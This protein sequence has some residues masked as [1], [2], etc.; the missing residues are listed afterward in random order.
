MKS[1]LGYNSCWVTKKDTSS[2]LM[3]SRKII[4]TLIRGP[5]SHH[6]SYIPKWNSVQNNSFK[7]QIVE[8]YFNFDEIL[9]H[10]LSNK[11]WKCIFR[12]LSHNLIINASNNAVNRP[13]SKQWTTQ[14]TQT[15]ECCRL[16]EKRLLNSLWHNFTQLQPPN[17]Y[18]TRYE[19]KSRFGA[20]MGSM[21][22][23]TVSETVRRLT[24]ST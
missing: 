9:L 17:N 22:L 5:I 8:R 4:M 3:N 20:P 13:I 12:P 23:V 6:F 19:L 16:H 18:T 15:R 24:V 10:E 1:A 2:I 11:Y 21:L 7:N 14:G